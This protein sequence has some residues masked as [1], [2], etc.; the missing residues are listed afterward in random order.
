MA[1]TPDTPSVPALEP[2]P[3]LFANGAPERPNPC[4]AGDC[5]PKAWGSLAFD[6]EYVLWWLAGSRNVS[7][8]AS[9][10]VL[11]NPGALVI[12]NLGDARNVNDRPLSGGRMTFG[13]WQVEDNPYVPGGIRDLEVSAVFFVIGETSIDFRGDQP[14]LVRPFFDVNNRKESGFLIAAP[15]VATGTLSAHAQVNLWGAEVNAWKNVCYDYPGTTYIV[16]L[17]AGFRYLSA[18]SGIQISSSS[19]YSATLPPTSPYFPLAGNSLGIFDSFA[20][21][22]RFYGGQVG[23]RS[24]MWVLEKL[25]VE[26]AFKLAL[27]ATSED[28]NIVGNQ[29]RIFPNGT[30]QNFVGGLLALPS[31]IGSFHRDKFAQVP[32]LDLKL[33]VPL[34]QRLTL[35]TGFTSIFWN[36]LV[37]A[38]Q[39][40]DREIDITQIPNFPLAAGAVPTGLQRP[41]VP[42][43]QSDLWMLGFS[44]GLEINW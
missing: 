34:T 29:V 38:G 28:V 8:I 4:F 2:V 10:D 30:S 3:M 12:E 16:D 39:Q 1:K 21:H 15:G 22:N 32:E 23:I 35:S 33:L 20:T 36:R 11:T 41:A 19:V 9:T 40:I 42:F 5:E 37:R 25:A 17:M 26:G 14:T 13:Y 7:S 43:K 18:D 44:F 27:G 31:N 6:A 24:K